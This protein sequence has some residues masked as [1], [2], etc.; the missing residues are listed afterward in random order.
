MQTL[1]KRPV[2]W[3]ARAEIVTV[4]IGAAALIASLGLVL[5][6]G[7][8]PRG[9]PAFPALVLLVSTTVIAGI[10]LLYRH[11]GRRRIQLQSDEVIEK[12]VEAKVEKKMD[13]WMGGEK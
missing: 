8:P 1:E 7:I 6:Y 5:T 11:L 2:G 9:A 12:K 10:I 13:K 4:L 3:A